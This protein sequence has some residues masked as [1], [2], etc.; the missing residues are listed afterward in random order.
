M[1]RLRWCQ[2]QRPADH[3]GGVAGQKEVDYTDLVPLADTIGPV[4][5]QPD[6]SASISHF[7]YNHY[8]R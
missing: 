6:A 8:V 5:L 3:Y 2:Q 1:T 7:F 4:F